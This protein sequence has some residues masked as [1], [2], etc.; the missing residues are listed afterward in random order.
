MQIVAL[1]PSDGARASATIAIAQRVPNASA[2]YG[3]SE[4][5]APDLR[6][7]PARD[8][9]GRLGVRRPRL[10]DGV[11]DRPHAG[12]AEPVLD[13]PAR[14]AVVAPPDSRIVGGGV[15]WTPVTIDARTN[16]V[17][18]GTGSGDAAL[19]PEPPPGPNPRTNSLIAVDLRTGRLK[20][21]RQLIVANAVE[22]RR[23]AAA[24]RLRRAGRRERRA[25]SSRSRRWRASGSRSTRAPGEPLHERVKVI[26]R[27]EHPPLRPGRAGDD[28]PVLARRPQLLA[29]LVRPG[30]ELRLQRRR[31]DRRRP[32]PGAADADAEA[33]ASWSSA[34]SSSGSRTA[35]SAG[36]PGLEGP[37]L[38]QR[39]RR[40]HRPARLEVPD[41]RAGARRRH[42]DRE[43]AR[44]RRRRRRR[45]A[46]VRPPDRAGALEVPD[47]A[48]RSP[49][50]RRSSPRGGR[51]YVAITVG[52]T[53]TSSNGGTA[54][55]LQVFALGGPGSRSSPSR[56]RS[57]CSRSVCAGAGR[58]PRAAPAGDRRRRAPDRGST[59]GADPARRSGGRRRSNQQA[60]DRPRAPRRPARRRRAR[61]VDRYVLPRATDAQG[62][63][64]ATVDITLARRH[65]VR[66]VG[67]ARARVDGRPLSAGG[68]AALL[69][70]AGRDHRRLPPD[71]PAGRRAG[72]ADG[73]RHR[74]RRCGR[75]ARP[76]RPS[77]CSPTGS[78]GRSP[79]ADG[80][81][82]RGATVVTRTLDRDFWTFSEPSDANGR[83]VSF[84]AASDEVG[85]RPRAAQ[86]PG[87]G[88]PRL[89]HVRHAER[90]RQAPAQ[91]RAGRPAPRFGPT[92]P[93]PE[94]TS[95][96]GAIYQGLL[97]GVSGPSGP[98]RP[99]SARWPDARGRFALVLP[100][101]ARGQVLRLWE[102]DFQAFSRVPARPGGAVDL[103]AWPTAL[104]PR[105]ARDVAFV[106]A[107]R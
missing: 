3:Y 4:T 19:L 100:P 42:D 57:A 46:R 17:Y 1:R 86:R 106:R 18:F 85:L 73:R 60:G 55:E 30:D 43:R 75:T 8:R 12:L 78:R 74:P 38:D 36:A 101:S 63:F 91:R 20:W 51:Q 47:R 16:T 66:V 27:V 94:A 93:L 5:S 92:I 90:D 6:E 102:S 13:D 44:V 69:R 24:A 80:R 9:R 64:T 84:F 40:R 96:S 70:A 33:A 52:G 88:R 32:D 81:P 95:T 34:T 87:R 79:D 50:A 31:R 41:A 35:T 22:L 21:W 97:V 23:R 68:R 39:D 26:D 14:P 107:P 71:R 83:Y 25:A 62:R 82:V 77:S 105:V 72:R 49:P 99:V 54:L 61:R 28:L 103:R 104:S 7:R 2:N 89:V 37:R 10:R 29:G 67:V 58:A 98:I 45:P 76:R 65:P 15:V 53:P 11:Q 56:V 48:T 59:G